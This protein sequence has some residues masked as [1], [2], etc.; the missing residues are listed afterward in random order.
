MSYGLLRTHNKSKSPF[1]EPGVVD[2][3]KV[4]LGGGVGVGGEV[5]PVG[6]YGRCDSA[7]GPLR[8]QN[9]ALKG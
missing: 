9:E 6:S 4:G 3:D 7:G 1:V 2:V 8:Q 5:C